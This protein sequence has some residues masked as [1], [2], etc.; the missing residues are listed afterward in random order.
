MGN[1]PTHP[2]W[3]YVC[4]VNHF[5]K[6]KTSPLLFVKLKLIYLLKYVHSHY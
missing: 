5:R 3:P 6:L 4:D 1:S 2:K